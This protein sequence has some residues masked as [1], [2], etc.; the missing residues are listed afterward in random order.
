[1]HLRIIYILINKSDYLLQLNLLKSKEID[2]VLCD[3]MNTACHEAANTLKIP[4]IITS[5]GTS[6]DG[7][8]A[9]YINNSPIN[10]DSPTTEDETLTE[11]L[12]NNWIKPIRFLIK[13]RKFLFEQHAKLKTLGIDPVFPGDLRYKDCV[14][15]FNSA[16]GFEFGRPLG[17][18]IELVGPIVPEKTARKLSPDIEEF[19]Q[20]HERVAY[21]AFGQHARA[22]ESDITLILTGLIEAYE[23]NEL[24]GIIWA[25]RGIEEH[26]FPEVIVSQNNVTYHIHSFFKN[27]KTGDIKFL[28]WAPQLAILSHPSTRVFVSHGGTGSIQ[29]AYFGGVRLIVYPFFADQIPNAITVEK[30]GTGRHLDFRSMQ[31][32]ATKLIKSVVKDDLG[33]FQKNVDKFKALTQIKSKH[34]PI[35]G[36]DVTEEVLFMHEN[37][38][39]PHR[40]DAKLRMSW[41]KANNLDMYA[42]IAGVLTAFLSLSLYLIFT[43]FKLISKT[44]KTQTKLKTF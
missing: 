27:S 28:N 6:G 23:T 41:I 34:G 31:D 19:L 40:L 11:R 8:T 15:I 39:L 18:L 42:V 7:T 36:A 4:F 26:Q 29:E 25:T 12:Y 20:T 14:K 38:L 33:Q 37:G 3:F 5:S 35:R 17:P 22:N 43:A 24:D 21:T 44:I 2:L 10:M 30:F 1:M 13:L 32:E 9:P 16:W